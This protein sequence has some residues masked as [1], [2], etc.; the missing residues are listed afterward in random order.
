[1]ER[2]QNQGKTGVKPSFFAVAMLALAGCQSAQPISA[3]QR[4]IDPQD[5]ANAIQSECAIYYAVN[6]QRVDLGLPVIAALTQGCP[7][8]TDSLP[9]DIAPRPNVIP[10]TSLAQTVRRRMIARGMPA[11]TA[12]QVATSRAFANLITEIAAL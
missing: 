2:S 3:P 5:Q 11:Q 7:A 4:V 9:A 1:M 6:A 10:A 12:N 8:G